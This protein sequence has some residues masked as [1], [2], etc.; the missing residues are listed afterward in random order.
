[1]NSKER[2]QMTLRHQKA[3]KMPV[4]YMFEDYR[5]M[6]RLSCHLGMSYDEM[7][8]YLGCDITYC[9]VM[10]EIQKFVYNPELMEF[11]L[12]N[13]FAIK[14]KNDP[15]VVYDR[16][17]LGW[18]TDHDGERP[19]GNVVIPDISQVHDFVAPVSNV[20]G[21]LHELEAI[22]DKYNE[23]GIAVGVGQYYGLFEKSYL[24]LGYEACLMSHYDNPDELEILL[25]KIMEYR[26][27][28]AEMLVQYD[29][30]F[31]HSGDD[32]GTQRG[33]VMSLELW[34]KF[35]KPRLEKI[36]AVYKKHG[37]SVV[38]HSCGDC[39]IFLD[40]MIDIGL[41]A[42]HP[43]QSAAM[44]VEALGKRYG[45]NLVFYGGIDCQRVLSNGTPDDVRDNVKYVVENLGRFGNMVLAPINIMR[46]VPLE[47][48]DALVESVNKYRVLD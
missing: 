5:T 1:M 18:R 47:N 41:D 17:G 14:D 44:D 37:L 45:N 25:D 48:F 16:W 46:D 12:K 21:Q 11:V 4:D 28:I 9:N 43:V 34:R 31:G 2:V 6:E 15:Y 24:L 42:I 22:V 23:Q 7:L 10:D 36:W 27:G 19:S 26:I 29:I 8:D 32:Y 38:H 39:S 13:G 33:P 20:P 35:Y 3:D 40:D 30:A